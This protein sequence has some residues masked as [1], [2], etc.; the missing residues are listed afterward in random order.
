M[1]QENVEIIRRGY[2]AWMS[3]G[4]PVSAFLDPDIELFIPTGDK[5]ITLAIEHGR[6]R[7]SGAEVE[8]RRTAHVWTLRDGLAVRLDLCL[9]RDRALEDLG[10]TD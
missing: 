2:E 4:S 7:G 9:D 6:G 10:L 1:S 5:V 3:S 8:H